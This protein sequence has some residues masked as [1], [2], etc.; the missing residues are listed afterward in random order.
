MAIC[1]PVVAQPPRQSAASSDVQAASERMAGILEPS[2]T[3]R[4]GGAEAIAAGGRGSQPPGGR[5]IRWSYR[6]V[7]DRL[8]GVR[9]REGRQ[10]L[11]QRRARLRLQRG[12]ASAA[13]P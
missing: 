9:G 8:E 11:A 7:E 13:P 2:G 6:Q 1:T 3:R 5:R 12:V 10:R 4:A